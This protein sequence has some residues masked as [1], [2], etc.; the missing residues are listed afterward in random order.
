MTDEIE[1]TGLLSDITQWLTRTVGY[2]IEKEGLPEAEAIILG[3]SEVVEDYVPVH[4]ADDLARAVRVLD[5]MLIPFSSTLADYGYESDLYDTAL[6]L[7]IHAKHYG[8]EDILETLEI[9]RPPYNLPK[10]VM[11]GFRD[12]SGDYLFVPPAQF[13]VLTAAQYEQLQE[14]YYESV[15]EYNDTAEAVGWT[16]DEYLKRM[17]GED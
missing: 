13:R 16:L 6:G 15:D 4:T 17:R 8:R 9:G 5:G 1:P 14:G 11:V 7:L 10:E 12:E 3:A 2:L